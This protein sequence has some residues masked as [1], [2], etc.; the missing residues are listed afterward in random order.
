MY[1]DEMHK[2]IKRVYV[3]TSV[4]GAVADEQVRRQQ[5]KPFWDAVHRGEIIIIVSDIL[6]DE[7]KGAPKIVRDFFDLLPESQIERVVSTDESDILAERYIAENVVGK[8]S[9]ADCKHVALATITH[10]DVLVSWNCKHVV[11]IER[12]KGYDSVN[13][14]LGYPRIAIRTPYPYEVIHDET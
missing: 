14:K 4:V 3:E 6:E 2:K 7:L 5:T 9:L 12:G 13:E 8:S 10:A 11:N 1:N